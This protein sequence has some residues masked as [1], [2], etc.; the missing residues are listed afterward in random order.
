M[1]VGKNAYLAAARVGTRT[2]KTKKVYLAAARVGTRTA[3]TPNSVLRTLG[4]GKVHQV[5]R[6]AG[7]LAYQ[8]D[9]PPL[10]G[11]FGRWRIFERHVLSQDPRVPKAP[12][13]FSRDEIPLLGDFESAKKF[14]GG[15]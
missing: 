8:K 12:N 15:V 6:P 2:A 10:L 14:E 7:V 1:E 4:R 5:Q 11:A 13:F 9:P 3:S